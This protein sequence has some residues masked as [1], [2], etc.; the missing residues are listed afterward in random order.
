MAFKIDTKIPIP[1]IT[2]ER[3]GKYPFDQMSPGDSFLVE[4]DVEMD[5]DGDV[6][7]KAWDEEIRLIKQ[8]LKG[9][10]ARYRKTGFPS[11]D[12]APTFYCKE[13]DAGV[14]CWMTDGAKDEG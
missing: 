8:R 12:V 1:N 3:T 6:D 11:L 2:N 4:P 10:C 5:E 13:V 7:Q 14:R 9:A